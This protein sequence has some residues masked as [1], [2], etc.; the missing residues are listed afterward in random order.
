MISIFP[1]V[2]GHGEERAVP[3]LLRRIA[4]DIT[5]RFDV[6]ILQPYR[7]PRGKIVAKNA[8]DLKKAVELGARKIADSTKT[9]MVMVL[10]DADDDCPAQLGPELLSKISRPDLPASVIIAK[11]EYEAWFLAGAQSL[12]K[13]RRIS[14][15]AVA[16]MNPEGIRG[17]K[18][19]LEQHLF[20]KGQ[21]YSETVDQEALTAVLDLTAARNAP[22]FDKLCRDLCAFLSAQP[23]TGA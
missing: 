7:L 22:S 8:V 2:E 23:V 1:I 17:A 16:P 14:S 5:C 6:K 19:Y 12:R 10:L 11:R 15:H 3:V 9:G 20:A 18:E 21:V 13:N 4:A